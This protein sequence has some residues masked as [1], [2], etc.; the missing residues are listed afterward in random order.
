MDGMDDDEIARLRVAVL[1][2]ARRMRTLS[3]EEG[4]T[5]AQSG[6]LAT[7]VRQGPTRAGDLAASEGLNPTMLSRM[8]G[9]LEDQGLIAR[10]ADPADRRGTRVEATPA[11]RRL[12]GRLRARHRSALTA[13]L[14]GL[15]PG[16]LAALR[17]ALPALEELACA[18]APD[19]RP[20][21][22]G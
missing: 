8:L 12:I 18:D 21:A 11:G 6:L 1:R 7:V 19:P 14:G 3:A 16:R 5:P 13:L 10:A 9:A 22:R 4:L 17:D 20:E 2:L 15:E